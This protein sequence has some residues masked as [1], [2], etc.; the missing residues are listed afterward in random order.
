MIITSDTPRHLLPLVG[1]HAARVLKKEVLGFCGISP[2]KVTRLGGVRW[3]TPR[4]RHAWLDK[5]GA[6]GRADA[7]QALP[8]PAPKPA[9]IPSGDLDDVPALEAQHLVG[10]G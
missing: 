6:L 3:T 4:Q 2:V 7:A 8:T 10:A 9:V 1:D 5:V